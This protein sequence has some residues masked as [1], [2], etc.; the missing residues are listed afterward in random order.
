MVLSQAKL[1][2]EAI[3]PAERGRAFVRC[4]QNF[5]RAEDDARADTFIRKAGDVVFKLGDHALLV[6]FKA[7]HA[8][9]LDARREFIKA[10][11]KYLDVMRSVEAG[12]VSVTEL[13]AFAEKA[14]ICAVLAPAGPQRARVMGTIMRLDEFQ[15]VK[16]GRP[17]RGEGASG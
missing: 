4:A 7:V 17:A 9:V 16:V 14:A 15:H 1:D 11:M 2:S 3:P 10:A 8:Q 12:Q 6:Q 5:I 13:V